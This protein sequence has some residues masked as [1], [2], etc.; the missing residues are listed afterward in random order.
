[1]RAVHAEWMQ[2]TG[3]VGLIPEPEFDEM[4]R[5]GGEWEK[6][7]SPAFSI[8]PGSADAVTIACATP[9]ASIAYTTDTSKR[10]RWNLYAG[11]VRLDRGQVLRAQ[12]GRIGFHDSG[13]GQFKFGD[14]P[15]G[16]AEPRSIVPDWRARIDRTD[17]LEQLRAIKA[18]DGQGEKAIP[19]YFGAL[20]DKDASVRYWAVVGLHHMTV[21]AQ[22]IEQAKAALVKLLDDPSPAVRVAAAEALCD[23][24]LEGRALPVLVDALTHEWDT[25]R[26]YA[27]NAFGRI[28]E[29][30]RRA[31]PQLKA[32]MEDKYP[33]VRNVTKYTLLR[34]E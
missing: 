29:K 34:L 27:A 9:G 8:T 22:T 12:A 3:D 4:K 14:K 28:G 7:A 25:V 2:R 11:P 26:L 21:G 32:A 13:E 24:G 33:Y 15:T 30:A 19:A 6:T 1:M 5:P 20:G 17:L 23:W 18:L 16:P 10:A 31:L